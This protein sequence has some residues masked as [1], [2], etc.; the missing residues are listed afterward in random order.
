VAILFNYKHKLE[1]NNGFTCPKSASDAPLRRWLPPPLPLPGVPTSTNLKLILTPRP[2][3]TE[4][5]PLAP[6]TSPSTS[7]SAHRTAGRSKVQRCDDLMLTLSPLQPRRLF[8]EVLVS[9]S[10]AVKD[11][12]GWVKVVSRRSLRQCQLPSAP[13]SSAYPINLQ[14]NCF[15]CLSPSHHVASRRC[16]VRCFLCQLPG[17][18]AYVCLQRRKAPSSSRHSLVWQPIGHLPCPVRCFLCQLPGHRAYVC[19]QRRKA[20][21]S[22]RHSLVWQPIGHSPCPVASSAC[23]MDASSTGISVI[24]GGGEKKRTRRSRRKKHGTVHLFI[25]KVNRLCTELQSYPSRF[26]THC[27]QMTSGQ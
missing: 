22:S 7:S 19:L 13:P 6:G 27:L 21:S 14:G 4:H 18:R 20:P 3:T 2:A 12:G 24:S 11:D 25:E 10:P 17:H 23:S 16:S 5:L 8:K 26:Y 1:S 15:K 9:S